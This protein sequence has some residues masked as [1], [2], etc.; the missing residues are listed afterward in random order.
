M[1]ATAFFILF[2]LFIYFFFKETKYAKLNSPINENV[3]ILVE[4]NKRNKR[5]AKKRQLL[6][7]AFHFG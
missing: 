2:L 7:M 4:K 6:S 3:L 5:R 1:V